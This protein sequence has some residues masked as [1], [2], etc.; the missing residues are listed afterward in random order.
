MDLI[1]AV[2]VLG[3]RVVRLTRGDFDQVDAYEGEPSEVAVSWMRRGAT[4]VH[5][6]DLNGA[7]TGRPTPGV[8]EPFGAA[9]VAFQAG[10]GIRGAAGALAALGAGARRVVVGSAAVA[11]GEALG[12]I[13]DAVGRDAV[14]AALDV[15][16]GRAVGSGWV[17]R[18]SD[19]MAVLGSLEEIGVQRVLVTG[20]SR[21]GTLGGPDIE[22][23]ERVQSAAPRLAVIA[24]GGVGNLE[25]VAALAALG[26]EGAIVGRALYEKA[27]T[28][29]DAL[30][31]AATTEPG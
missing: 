27:F 19:V 30:V 14:V 17:D 8:L 11:S 28:L 9:G 12:S 24:S 21:D 15:R 6:V 2:D 4:F 31:V 22:L 16:D 13:I 26:F 23:L 20:I 29:E 7:R 18:G 1:P 5:V 25:D 10:G 3:G